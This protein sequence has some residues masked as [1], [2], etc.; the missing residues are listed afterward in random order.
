MTVSASKRA[1][2][3]IALWAAGVL[4]VVSLVVLTSYSALQYNAMRA[5]SARLTQLEQQVDDL[6]TDQRLL[7]AIVASGALTATS[8]PSASTTKTL[9]NTPAPPVAPG[10]RRVFGSIRRA[11][12]K[13][14]G[15]E[16]TVDPSEYVTGTAAFSLASS[17]GKLT[18]S[19]GS[20]VLDTSDRTS[21]FKLLKD[22]K[23]T[24]VAWPGAAKSK[25]PSILASELISVLPGG[26]A[27]DATWAKAWFWLDVRDGYVLQVT[28][29]RVD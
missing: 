25:N 21:Q 20:F 26:D 4:A 11:E 18:N 10:T 6:S 17:L 27:V 22:A 8:G 7:A 9:E 1:A 28:Q 12:K 3:V 19:D 5:Q 16:L 13:P 14:Y 2:G 23:V 24:V 15:W 29:Q